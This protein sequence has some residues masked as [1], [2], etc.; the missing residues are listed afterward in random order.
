M[1][2]EGEPSYEQYDSIVRL[3]EILPD[4]TI[5]ETTLDSVS[6]KIPVLSL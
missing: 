3:T 2:K 1:E 6:K 5:K 4:G